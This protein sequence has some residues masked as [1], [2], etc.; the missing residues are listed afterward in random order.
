MLCY[1][2]G[3][4]TPDESRKCVVCGQPIAKRRRSTR[5]ATGSTTGPRRTVPPFDPGEVL[6]GRYRISEP[7]APG[8]SG[9]VLRA[10]DEEV[11]VDVAIKVMAANLLQTDEDRAN[12][13]KVVKQARKVHHQNIVRIYDEGRG[14][15]NI[16]Y[17]MPFLEGLSLRKI[18]DLRLEK[19]QVFRVAEALPLFGQL[20]LA[21]DNLDKNGPHGAIRPGNV[22]VLPDVLKVTGLPHLRG[23]PR[24]PFVA[25]QTQ[26][27]CVDYLAPEVQSDDTVDCRADVYSASVLFG[28]MLT[29]QVYNRA[30]DN[31]SIIERSMP[32]R[33]VGVLRQGLSESPSARF[34]SGAALFEALAGAAA[35]AKLASKVPTPPSAIIDESTMVDVGIAEIAAHEGP[36]EEPVVNVVSVKGLD[37]EVDIADEQ[38]LRLTKPSRHAVPVSPQSISTARRGGLRAIPASRRSAWVLMAAATIV[39]AG[40]AVSAAI[41]VSQRPNTPILQ[42]LPDAMVPANVPFVLET[43][44][45]NGK[46][47]KVGRDKP[48]IPVERKG[49]R[50]ETKPHSRDERGEDLRDP[51]DPF[52]MA[53]TAPPAMVPTTR[54]V[55]PPQLA[56]AI[57]PVGGDR[58]PVAPG[59]GVPVVPVSPTPEPP[60][61]PAL[62][63]PPSPVALVVTPPTTAPES[64][65]ADRCPPGM[66]AIEAGTFQVGSSGSDPMRGFGELDAHTRKLD[67]YCVDIY[68]FPNQRGKL[69]TTNISWS[70]AK[71]ACERVNKRMCSEAEW[72]RA[73]KGPSGTRFPYGNNF[74]K[75]YCNVSDGAS[76]S[77]TVGP[78]GVY[79][80][81]RSGFGVVDLA[82]NVAEWTA[83]SWG[84]GVPDKVV[85]GGAADQAHYMSRCA[86]RANESS[87]GRQSNIGFRCCADLKQ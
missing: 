81:C 6:V 48:T 7:I 73:C 33:L 49:R 77:R 87:G 26:A 10:R 27:G 44:T 52:D 42:P 31:W 79:G 15:R 3:S 80:R 61:P 69:P 8:T 47:P 84:K 66:L 53:P 51:V 85:K 13:L 5:N 56:P 70:R 19:K 18:I 36:A 43:A 40:I 58:R 37:E 55:P 57:A 65:G 60:A 62:R 75:S 32:A 16:F 67:G 72:E 35:D 9:W 64:G 74:D 4:F 71:K 68:E 41:F 23:L 11:D 2:C 21:I 50:T 38:P 17:T 63:S 1:R 46:K 29:G 78:T 45:P 22:I 82:G 25:L 28:E 83:S 20:A 54:A 24:K 76:E 30:T 86:A 59:G 14:E 34:E 39:L 12:F